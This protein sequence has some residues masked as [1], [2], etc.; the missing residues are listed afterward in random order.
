MIQNVVKRQKVLA[1]QTRKIITLKIVTR[2]LTSGFTYIKITKKR[3]RKLFGTLQI[4]DTD[5]FYAL[6]KVFVVG[7]SF[8]ISLYTLITLF[9]SWV[10]HVQLK[11]YNVFLYHEVIRYWGFKQS[12]HINTNQFDLKD[13]YILTLWR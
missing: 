8:K 11:C 6:I 5:L 4:H 7:R 12:F 9:S 3:C 10:A 13:W 1:Q 2:K